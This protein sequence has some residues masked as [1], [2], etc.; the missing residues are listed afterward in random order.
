MPDSNSSDNLRLFRVYNHYRVT[1]GFVL[2]ILTAFSPEKSQSAA[3]D[4]HRLILFTYFGLHLFSALL[5]YAG[6]RPNRFHM[7][8]SL[9]LELGLLTALIISGSGSASTSFSLANLMIVTVAAANILLDLRWGYF[10]A[11]VASLLLIG[12]ESLQV[13]LDH[14]R[15]GDILRAG[16]QGAAFFATAILVGQL[17]K[18]IRMTEALA[19]S[20]AE[21]IETLEELNHLI[22]QRMLTGII[23]ATAGGRVLLTNKAASDLL[24]LN[25]PDDLSSL[26]SILKER[27]NAWKLNPELRTLSFSGASAKAPI[28]AS[29]A[30]LQKG[31]LRS[32]IIFLEDTGKVSQQAQ[33]LKLMSLGRLTAGIAHEIRNPLGAASHAAQLLLESP[34][35]DGS[36]RKMT[37][38]IQRHCVRMNGIIE[39]VLQLSRGK[40]SQPEAIDLN[41]WLK[42]FLQDFTADGT[43]PYDISCNLSDTDINARFDP[44]HLN[45][46][47]TNLLSN[48]LRYSE[49]QTGEQRA[50]I[51][52]TRTEGEGQ[53]QLW[54]IDEGPGVSF[55]DRKHLFEPFFTTDKKGTGLGLYI[56][57]ELCEANQASLDY[58]EQKLGGC[59]RITF[60]HPLKSF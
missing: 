60:A 41:A 59:F 16:I 30:P 32:V 10:I 51:R 14:S 42:Q 25:S 47:L 46:I 29:F 56:S 55:E 2:V 3:A 49:K 50:E 1:V 17:S 23:V 19:R 31:D 21:D 53:I 6:L 15:P 24:G 7:A 58:V 4:I 9:I 22:I 37:E 20:R 38:I 5:L 54:V 28:Q 13:V 35:L 48:A 11:A 57:R 18:R 36:D 45:Q 26:P 34:D 44:S 27:L 8:G 12:Q 52:L 43:L 33:E 39:N 40:N